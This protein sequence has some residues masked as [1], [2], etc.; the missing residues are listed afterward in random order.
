MLRLFLL[1]SLLALP[2][3]TRAQAGQGTYIL[4]DNRLKTYT[5]TLEIFDRGLTAK[6]DR[7]KK[8]V[9]EAS[10]IY[11]ARVGNHRYLPVGG[12]Q[13][14]PAP[15]SRVEHGMAEL[16]DSGRVSLLRYDYNVG[17][18]GVGVADVGGGFSPG[19]AST[20]SVYLLQVPNEE[21]ALAIP[22]NRLT[23]KGAELRQMLAPYFASRADLVQQLESGAVTR[24]TLT[25]FVHA[26]N[27]GQP[28]VPKPGD[29]GSE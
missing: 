7:G 14:S 12:F 6:E 1:A 16:L 25:A 17:S 23:G 15:K 20:L 27:S 29:A 2:L 11:W 5:G 3:F 8:K 26:Y 18:P 28:F 4:V 10:E 24:R 19:Y 13:V 22:I 9:W 21:D